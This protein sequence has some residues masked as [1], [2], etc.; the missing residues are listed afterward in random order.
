MFVIEIEVWMIVLLLCQIHGE[1]MIIMLVKVFGWFGF[2]LV[3]CVRIL[4]RVGRASE[5][6]HV[7][8]I[9]T[10]QSLSF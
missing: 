2:I 4:W 9:F 5:S 7:D 8:M 10:A 6:V 1:I 3:F